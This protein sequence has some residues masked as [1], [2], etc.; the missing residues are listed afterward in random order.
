MK[1]MLVTVISDGSIGLKAKAVEVK[2]VIS[3]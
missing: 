3:S 2:A 1:M